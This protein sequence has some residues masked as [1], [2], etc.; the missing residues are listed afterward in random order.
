MKPSGSACFIVQY[1]TSEGRT[2]RL[3]IGKVGTLTPE[4]A[5]GLARD[6]LTAVAHGA[7]PSADRHKARQDGLTV[8]D[9]CDEYMTASRAG[10]VVTRFKRPKPQSTIRFDEGRIARHIK[11]LIG[12]QLASKL[13]RA[14][15]QKMIDGIAAGKTAGVFKTRSR[16]KA[17][18]TGGAGTAARVA[19]L[20]G[21]IW[22]WGERRGFVSGI[23]PVHGVQKVGSG[24]RDRIASMQELKQLGDWLRSREE[25]EPLNVAVV[26]LLA[27]TG[28]RRQE[29]CALKWHEIDF[30]GS[31]LRLETTK[32][33]RSLR[34][35]GA[36]ALTLFESIKRSESEFVFPARRGHGPAD[37][38]KG[39]S[40]LF[41]DAGLP[42]IRPQVLRRTF[43]SIAADHG[44]GDATIGELLGHARRGVTAK[45]YIRRPDPVLVAA[46]NQISNTIAAALDGEII[47]AE[48]VPMGRSSQMIQ[49]DS[50]LVMHSN[51]HRRMG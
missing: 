23:N 20:L 40:Q 30:G 36:S 1:R 13:T 26:R 5:R 19:G 22:N 8:G 34:A 50:A 33:G 43:A 44:Y 35:I 3:A 42:D 37:L 51:S 49:S 45:H 32:T 15:V 28:L 31:C 47:E 29:A 25:V 48:I 11:P 10:L 39:F 2:R 27:L 12:R 18:V 9:L 21:G 38:K 7:D 4:N 17:V 16:G 41:D 46:A 14:E 6:K 24:T